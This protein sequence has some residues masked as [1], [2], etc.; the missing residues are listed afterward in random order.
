MA[1]RGCKLADPRQFEAARVCPISSRAEVIFFDAT[2][3]LFEVRGSVGAIYSRI[4]NRHGLRTDPEQLEQAFGRAFLSQPA[5][6]HSLDDEL[7]LA[8]AEKQWWREVVE[9]ALEGRMAPESFPGYLEEVFE[10]FRNA[11]AWELYSDTRPGL[12]R[13]R[14]LGYRLAVISNF[15]SRLIDLL[16]NLNLHSFFEQAILSW[17]AGAAKP[18]AR[19][20]HYALELMR[21][22]A[23]GAVHVGDSME[24]DV[25]GA[26]NAGLTAV[27]F[28]RRQIHPDWRDGHR[29]ESFDSLLR[30]LGH[31]PGK[32]RPPQ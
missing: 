30:L 15:D 29:V 4:A 21:I 7:E 31:Q 14:S 23:A 27:L 8:L 32:D 9:G 20:F 16:A 11:E 1:T 26:Q 6:L 25:A 19:I 18:D 28:D 22:P 17:R 5:G 10:A 13:L 2:G 3:T 12:T 24:D